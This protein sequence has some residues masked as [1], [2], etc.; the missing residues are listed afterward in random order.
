MPKKYHIHAEHTP[1][2]FT[3]VG[4][5]GIVDFNEDCAGACHD[6]VKKSCIYEVYKKEGIF[7][8][9]IDGPVHYLYSCMNC[10]RCVQGCTR[11]VVTRVVNP[12]YTWLGDAYYKPDIVLTLWYQSETGSLPV[13]GAG[14]RGPFAGPGFDSMWTDMS[15]IVRP[16]RDGIHGRE[17]INTS[18][19]IGA[20]PDALAFDAKGRLAVD[21][22]PAVENPVPF[23][24]M[25]PP[26]GDFS[27]AVI[28][29]FARATHNMGAL[30][31]LPVADVTREIK[32][33][34]KSV[35][36]L[37]KS[38]EVR[39]NKA[40][41][42]AARLVML[43]YDAKYKSGV[44]AVKKLNPDAVA[45][46]RIALD[47]DSPALAE[48]LCQA[49][50]EAIQ[51]YADEHGNVGEGKNP[52]FIK[53]AFRRVH[54]HLVDKGVRDRITLIAE[55]GIALPEHMAKIIIC[56]ADL[57]A[58]D[59]PFLIALECRMCRNCTRGLD[60]PVCIRDV[61]PKKGAQRIMNL[62][63]A[64]RNQLLEVLGAMGIR[65][66][67]RLRGE[68]G[69]AMFYEDLE[70]D[71]FQKIFANGANKKNKAAAAK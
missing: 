63:A 42:K 53:D 17:Y 43:E 23:L 51:F 14:Y 19:D 71:T 45:C 27:P 61:D 22:P 11:A 52:E 30:C 68:V 21:M 47:K 3:P 34:R 59:L 28:E 24:L 48:T 64:W 4:K 29:S 69:R 57:A 10:L 25:K 41:I 70:R 56:G 58:V 40:L 1:P 2:R 37:L 39:K 18:V 46:L 66:V 60:C 54:N 31:V 13:S 26:F 35:A 33:F 8:R 50:V 16:T 55:G 20:K 6:C 36:P 7:A 9:D 32:R 5:F 49:G 65:E 62:S 44:Q 15:E 12:E 38:K 67:R